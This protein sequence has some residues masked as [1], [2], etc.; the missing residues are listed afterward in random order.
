MSNEL[1]DVRC[2]CGDEY[3]A[4]SYDAGFIA[5]SG[6]CQNCDAALPP[7]DIC[8]CPSGNGSLR[9][10]CPAHPAV[11][12]AGGDER[13]F[14]AEG[15][16]EVPSPVSQEYDR[17]LISLLRKGEALPGH[18][19]EAA[20]EIERLRDWNDHLNNTVLPNILNPTFLM[21]MKGGERLLDL[22]TKDGEFIGVSLNDMKDVFD[23]MVTHARIAPDQAALAQPSHA[24]ELAERGTQHRFSTTE[25]TCR[26]DFAGVWWNDNGE[27]K[28]GRECRHCGFFVAD[29]TKAQ[30][31]QAEAERPEVVAWRYGFSG[32]IVSDKACLD[33]WKSG[34]EYQSLMTVAQHE[35][36]VGELRAVIAQLRQHKNDYMDSGQ[37]TYRALQN[38]IREREAEIARLDGL[39]SGRTAERDAALAE[40]NRLRESKGDPSGSFDRC[41]RMM[42]E[43]DENAKRLDAA[44]ARVA[45]LEKQEPVA[46][47]AKVPGEDWNGLHFYRDLQGMQP[48]TKLYAAPVAQAQQLHDLDKQCRD[49]VAR[50]LG[51]RPS[52]ERGFAWSYLLA[53]IKSC[54][55]AAEDTA[56]AQHSVPDVCDGK[57]QNA[58]EDWA[59]KEGMNMERHPLHWL[60]LDAKTYSARQ[61]WKAAL[62]YARNMLA[63]A[64]VCRLSR[65]ALTEAQMR[66][67][68][69]NSTETE[70]ERLG[71]EAFARLIRRAEA[72]HQI[73]AAPGKE[74]V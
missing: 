1:T 63:A 66:R 71:F 64:P 45:E 42:Y 47:I 53:S 20:D 10:P 34:G 43:R 38:E 48:G 49:D 29:V 61:G 68:Y 27:T 40:V 11:E 15:A 18:Q 8:T 19:E 59:S 62:K 31:E 6:M 4:D 25:Q 24:P 30:A 65:S 58:F 67:L 7:K 52:Q 55:K 3:P 46:T 51:L 33:E 13:D 23:W 73:T 56:Q 26:H 72:V 44:L 35:R 28:T 32:G 21:L 50:A 17:H 37:E 22:C 9:H 70:N 69:E 74:G 54:V 60:F 5:G 2:S 14:Q 39:V 16:Q 12:Q 41:M 36:I 57:E